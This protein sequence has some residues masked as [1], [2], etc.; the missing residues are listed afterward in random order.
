M[1][2][3]LSLGASGEEVRDLHRRLAAAGHRLTSNLAHY[4]R[5]TATAIADFQTAHGLDATG[6]CDQTTW[7]TLV[8]ASYK[9]G[10]RAVY[11]TQPMLRGDDVADLQLRLGSLGF[12][13]GRADG[14]F[15]PE[16]ERAVA[17]FQRNAGLTS[18]G[19]AGQQTIAELVRLSAR[20]DTSRSVAQVRE[21]EELR[22]GPRQLAGLRI[23]VGENGPF[24]ALVHLVGRQ[25]RE[26][27]AVVLEEHHPD[28]STQARNANEFGAQVFVAITPGD[29][30][31]CDVAYFATTGF[32][33]AG[34][35][36]LA[37][38][39]A[40]QLPAALG[41][42]SG[43]ASGMRLAILRETRMPAVLCRLGSPARVVSHNARLAT[44]LVTALHQW[45]ETPPVND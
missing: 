12:D 43:T 30:D 2:L 18:D 23:A 28:W 7:N 36:H 39:C 21:A 1:S 40:E 17:D 26:Q 31:H 37:T 34:G 6:I 45:V 5:S 11:H 22:S 4:G 9:L 27:G 10:D 29:N 35:R 25:L 44:T 3:P 19:V 32:A 42:A 14:I 13:A 16:T 8:E 33:S 41:I 24:H 20:A 38:I 15:G